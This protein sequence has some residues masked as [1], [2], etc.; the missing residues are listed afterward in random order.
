MLKK[1]SC[2]FLLS[3][4][5]LCAG[6]AQGQSYTEYLGRKRPGPT[7]YSPKYLIPYKDNGFSEPRRRR[8][9]RA[10]KL[11]APASV[12]NEINAFPGSSDAIGRWID[13]AYDEAVASFTRCGGRLAEFASRMT[14]GTLAGGVSIES[15]VWFE[16]ALQIYVAGAYYPSTRSIRVLN[17]YYSTRGDYRHAR[18]LLRWE[19]KNH[20]GAL[21]GLRSEP[22]D[23]NWP[24]NA[25]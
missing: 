3:F 1:I 6:P 10:Q 21:A 5:S 15:T 12:I 23:P 25:R 2:I 11:G 19:M 14:P 17:L 13:E 20:F 16:P 8:W 4:V 18:N 22:Y 24:C 9:K 7:K